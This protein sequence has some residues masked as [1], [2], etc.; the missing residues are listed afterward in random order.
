MV[1][2]QPV[3]AAP[4][5]GC[6]ISPANNVIGLPENGCETSALKQSIDACTVVSPITQTITN[7]AYADDIF[8][9]DIVCTDGSGNS[10]FFNSTTSPI[11][12]KTLDNYF[13][14]ENIGPVAF[15]Q[16]PVYN[17]V[18][19]PDG[20]YNA[21]SAPSFVSGYIGT[22]A[23][24]DQAGSNAFFFFESAPY[25]LNDISGG[26]I[27]FW[28]KPNFVSGIHRLFIAIA[29]APG[30]GAGI[31]QVAGLG[32]KYG[33]ISGGLFSGLYPSYF[34]SDWVNVALVTDPIGTRLYL[35]GVLVDSHVSVLSHPISLGYFF[36]YGG[37]IL[38]EVRT[39]IGALTGSE[40][41]QAAGLP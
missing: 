7:G 26:T 32:I 40:I 11:I 14:F 20:V 23:R 34:G 41:R 15:G 22:G 28:A 13:T 37:Y 10:Y 33:I 30:Y 24:L 25:S 35:D 12:P 3:N 18:D 17:E 36:Q 29:L 2:V 16:Y 6:T 39:Y 21:F 27:M 5:I 8:T 1:I 19:S 38:D 9:A 4:A 31:E